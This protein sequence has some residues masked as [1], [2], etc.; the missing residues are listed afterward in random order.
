MELEWKTCAV[1]MLETSPESVADNPFDLEIQLPDYMPD[2]HR[3]LHCAVIPQI[4]AISSIGDRVNV[5]GVG[6][7]R[8]LY[9]S[10]DGSAHVYE[11]SFPLRRTVPENIQGANIRVN[12]ATDYVNCRA[13]GQREASVNGSVSMHFVSVSRR[14]MQIPSASDSDGLQTQVDRLTALSLSACTE[15]IFAM[16]EVVELENDPPIGGILCSRTYTRVDAVKAVSDK[17]LV[18]G[19]VVTR[20]Q[21]LSATDGNTIASYSHS[22]PINQVIEAIGVTETD[23]LDVTLHVLSSVTVPKTDGSGD[24]RLLEITLQIGASVRCYAQIETDTICDAY[25]TTASLVPKFTD[26]DL[27]TSCVR[28]QDS[29]RVHE[30]ADIAGLGLQSVQFVFVRDVQCNCAVKDGMAVAQCTATL[31][32]LGQNI[33]GSDVWVEKP[34]E[35]SCKKALTDDATLYH[36]E[37]NVCLT[38][39]TASVLDDGTLDVQA[40][41]F[42]DATIYSGNTV[43]ILTAATAEPFSQDSDPAAL[44]IYF[45]DEGERVWDIARRYRTT[46]EAVSTENGLTN[47]TVAE[48]RMLVI[49]LA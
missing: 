32:L 5:E 37:T 45:A 1:G 28:W 17:I 15:K 34:I 31:E 16:S 27:F 47:G 18:K 23:F 7:V 11:Q 2:I 49:P 29:V 41:G 40:D 46:V 35:F 38:Q 3:I 44:T 24:N 20:V 26:V 39:C 33:D 30:K 43:R 9:C 13:A 12:A 19:E 8:L 36:C 22:M 4:Q 42:I 6:E 10:E 14:E 48:K 25:S 21:Y